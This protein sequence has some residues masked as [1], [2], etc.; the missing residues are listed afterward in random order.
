MT[1]PELS[2]VVVAWKSREDVRAL[3][4]GQPA[5]PRFE[6]VIVDN[7][8]DVTTAGSADGSVRVVA[9]GRNLGFAAGS[10]AGARAARAPW[11]LFLNPDARPRPGAGALTTDR[12]CGGQPDRSG[13]RRGQPGR[14]PGPT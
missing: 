9:P 5:D 2:I 7:S 6:L 14:E 10:N 3:A 4:A 12:P 13:V 11:L 1:R 8:G